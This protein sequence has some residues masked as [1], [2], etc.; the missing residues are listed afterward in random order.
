MPEP[1]TA[2]FISLPTQL[3]SHGWILALKP[4]ALATYIC[5]RLIGAR[6]GRA[7]ALDF[8]DRGRT[9]L[10][11]DTIARGVRQLRD[12]GI[13]DQRPA[14]VEDRYRRRRP[15]PRALLVDDDRVVLDLI[16]EPVNSRERWDGKW[17]SALEV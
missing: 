5:L 16:T 7:V 6:K 13:V 14:V 8:L 12:L 11:D 3:W 15:H 10:S 9:G 4:P 2:P 17:A 1:Q